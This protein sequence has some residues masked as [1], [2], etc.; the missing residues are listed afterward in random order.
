MIALSHDLEAV[1]LQDVTQVLIDE[2]TTDG[3]VHRVVEGGEELGV[4]ARDELVDSG[5]NAQ[6][7]H[8]LLVINDQRVVHVEAHPIAARHLQIA[9]DEHPVRLRDGHHHALGRFGHWEW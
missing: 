8:A 4:A 1:H 9:I 5:A 6:F 7:V 2:Q 3:E